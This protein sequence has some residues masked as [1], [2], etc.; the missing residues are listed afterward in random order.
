MKRFILNIIV[1]GALVIVAYPYRAVIVERAQ[2]LWANIEN[3]FFPTNPCTQ[4]TAYTLG[5]FDTKFNI[6]QKYFLEALAEAE[7]IWEKPTGKNLFEYTASDSPKTLKVN[8]IYDYRQQATTKLKSLDISIENNRASYDALK[9]KFES[10]KTKYEAE[11]ASFAKAVEAFNKKQQAYEQEVS[12]W[13][14]KGGAPQGEYERLEAERR[15]LHTESQNLEDRQNNLNDMA[16]EINALVVALNRIAAT[17][18]ISAEKYNATNIARGESF[19]EGVYSTDGFHKEIDIYEF[20][21]REKLVRVLAHELGHSLGLDHVPD[22]KAIMYEKNE[23]NSKVLTKADLE[24]FNK[25]C[26]N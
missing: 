5:K 8:L 14:K 7:A 9:V 26:Y 19:E 17:L 1:L 3:R 4:I 25:I 10:L 6:S 21:T 18:N 13:N 23:G 20:S 12:S 15:E 22:S 24:A 2:I 11:K 16:E